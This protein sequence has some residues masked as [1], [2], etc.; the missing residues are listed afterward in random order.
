M[1]STHS[2]N[3]SHHA[4]KVDSYDISSPVRKV[5]YRQVINESYPKHT[6]ANVSSSGIPHVGPRGVTTKKSYRERARSA[7][8]KAKAKMH[9]PTHS[10][11]STMVWFLVLI[12]IVVIIIGIL[13]LVSHNRKHGNTKGETCTANKDCAKD[14]FCSG[15]KTCQE[16]VNGKDIGQTCS[17]SK[18]CE[19]DLGCSSGKCQLLTNGS[20]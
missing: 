14:H 16:G 5:S 6:Y 4:V 1:V 9:G 11:S 20:S 8:H 7:F 2:P 3:F 17:S 19:V 10:K 18:E 13:A 15:D 12:V